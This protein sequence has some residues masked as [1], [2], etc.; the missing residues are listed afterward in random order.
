MERL[1]RFI[2]TFLSSLRC[3]HF[4]GT[5]SDA[6]REN[7]RIVCMDRGFERRR[8]VPYR[9][10]KMGGNRRAMAVVEVDTYQH[11]RAVYQFPHQDSEVEKG[12]DVYA[13]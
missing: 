9:T 3:L 1:G 2:P 8:A 13:N 12:G 6:A 11:S 7:H 10:K 4:V 5:T